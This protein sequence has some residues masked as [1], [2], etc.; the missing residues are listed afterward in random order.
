MG[1]K[2]NGYSV[3]VRE[4]HKKLGV[5][6]AE[7]FAALRE[8]WKNISKDEKSIYDSKARALNKN[9]KKQTNTGLPFEEL[10]KLEI[11]AKRKAEEERRWIEKKVYGSSGKKSLSDLSETRFFVIHFNKHVVTHDRQVVPAEM[12]LVRF[13]LKYGVENETSCIIK[14]DKKKLPLGYAFKMQERAMST[15]AIPVN[16]NFPLAEDSD[17][18]VEKI[19]SFLSS[20]NDLTCDNLV[21]PPVFTL[22]FKIERVDHTIEDQIADDQKI[23][24]NLF[25]NA[26]NDIKAP[27]VYNIN[28]LFCAMWRSWIRHGGNS[29]IF[30]ETLLET[31]LQTKLEEDMF[32]YECSSPDCCGFHSRLEGYTDHYIAKYCSLCIS[33]RYAFMICSFL[34]PN[35]C[36]SVECI[37][38]KHKPTP[39]YSLVKGESND[40]MKLKNAVSMAVLKEYT[41]P[42]SGVELPRCGSMNGTT[43]LPQDKDPAIAIKEQLKLK[44]H[45]LKIEEDEFKHEKKV[46]DNENYSFKQSMDSSVKSDHPHSK[47]QRNL[48]RRLWARFDQVDD[49]H[50][51]SDDRS[52]TMYHSYM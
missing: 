16:Q 27:I 50:T 3:Y 52:E 41:N 40:E 51:K 2:P 46:I 7:G 43:F 13:S 30:P 5:T 23:L 42:I 22:N 33:K 24:N 36:S 28:N 29:M 31:V 25:E 14:C 20:E 45:R 18:V 38:G 35:V 4:N 9:R 19:V 49:D 12:G 44:I 11:I 10:E 37:D 48:S 47:S 39:E 26:G 15:H 21:L 1:P 17:I 32:V 8:Q 34:T 6:Y